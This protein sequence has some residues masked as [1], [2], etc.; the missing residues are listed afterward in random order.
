MQLCEMSRIGLG[1]MMSARAGA[2]LTCRAA[3]GDEGHRPSGAGL[4]AATGDESEGAG[5]LA[6]RGG[7]CCPESRKRE[8]GREM[9][10]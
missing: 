10:A 6:H 8:W 4:K 3:S 5:G 2:T 9:M 7:V 1:V